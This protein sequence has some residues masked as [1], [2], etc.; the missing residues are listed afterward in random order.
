MGFTRYKPKRW[1]PEFNLVVIDSIKGMSNVEIGKKYGYTPQH[2]SNILCTEQAAE[3]KES[4][5][6]GIQNHFKASFADE[7]NDLGR[8]AFEHIKD[9]VKD[10]LNLKTKS[11]FAFVDKMMKV[12]VM[13]NTLSSNEKNSN[14]SNVTIN[15]NNIEKAIVISSEA[16]NNL[17]DA[18]LES[19]ELDAI[20]IGDSNIK[21]RNLNSPKLVKV[22]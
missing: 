17:K 22:S 13:T 11:P 5:G 14:N 8:Q 9:F 12:A 18:I 16:A 10:D 4:I 2:V 15:Q 1:H 6:K 7:A 3:L 21:D 20:S 19:R